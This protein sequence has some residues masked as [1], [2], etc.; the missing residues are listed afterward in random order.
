MSRRPPPPS[1]SKS[2]NNKNS[3]IPPR[4]P[5]AKTSLALLNSNSDHRPEP[6]PRNGSA[7]QTPPHSNKFNHSKDSSSGIDLDSIE[8]YSVTFHSQ[9]CGL[10]IVPFDEMF[11]LGGIVRSCHTAVASENVIINS[12]I[13]AV[14]NDIVFTDSYENIVHKISTAS[15]PLTVTF[16]PPEFDVSDENDI[17]EFHTTDDGSGN[18]SNNNEFESKQKEPLQGIK[19]KHKHQQKQNQTTNST[20]NNQKLRD[21]VTTPLDSESSVAS[22]SVDEAF[23]SSNSDHNTNVLQAKQKVNSKRKQH[24]QNNNN[25]KSKIGKIGFTNNRNNNNTSN[26]NNNNNNFRS[27]YPITSQTPTARHFHMNVNNS[28][29]NNAN[30]GKTVSFSPE[31]KPMSNKHAPYSKRGKLNENERM[32]EE[33]DS[34]DDEFLGIQDRILSP[35][36]LF[37]DLIEKM[38]N[39]SIGYSMI[40]IKVK[41]IY[42]FYNAL[43]THN[44]EM[45][46]FIDLTKHEIDNKVKDIQ[47]FRQQNNK[48]NNQVLVA[49]KE[50]QDLEVKFLMH[51]KDA[52]KTHNEHLKEALSILFCNV[53]SYSHVNRKI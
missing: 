27:K 19:S 53:F 26:N 42:D 50:K 46:K 44:V 30:I 1:K 2:K 11:E 10:N 21:S 23:D 39:E 14:N 34:D 35:D 25:I 15:R 49:T 33:F 12:L 24:K 5:R 13:I 51:R 41:E 37:G 16:H 17:I 48:L 3:T 52:T 45:Q 40:Y 20:Q 6:P 32:M 43:Y 28:K 8:T 36:E 38:S 9:V 29:F 7:S 47:K 31:S 18:H 4:K 22:L